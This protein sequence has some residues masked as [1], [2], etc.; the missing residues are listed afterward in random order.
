MEKGCTYR[1][2]LVLILLCKSSKKEIATDGYEV[3]EEHEQLVW[4]EK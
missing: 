4:S 1:K 3:L 2:A